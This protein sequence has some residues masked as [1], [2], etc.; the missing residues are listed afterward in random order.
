MGCGSDS[1]FSVYSIDS[2][3]HLRQADAAADVGHLR[4]DGGA[5]GRCGCR[6]VAGLSDAFLVGLRDLDSARTVLVHLLGSLSIT[7][8]VEKDAAA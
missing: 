7:G 2:T 3:C 6:R 4:S 8:Y 1:F 5:D